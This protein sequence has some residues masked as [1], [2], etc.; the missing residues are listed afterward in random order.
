MNGPCLKQVVTATIVTPDGERF[1]AMNDCENPQTVCP[2]DRLATG[3]G[4]HLCRD[5]CRQTG[6]AEVNAL[7]RA[8]AKARG[9]ILYLEGHTYA[10]EP[11]KAACEA[12]GICGSSL[13]RPQALWPL[14]FNNSI[15]AP[16]T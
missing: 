10:C 14:P 8:G 11:C 12:A 13:G 3:V 2:R 4:Y 6:H 15:P 5:V 16:N 9:A 1:V 7:Q